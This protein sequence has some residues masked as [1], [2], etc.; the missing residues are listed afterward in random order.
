SRK[1][2]DAEADPKDLRSLRA[3]M[4]ALAASLGEYGAQPLGDYR[5][6]GNAVHN[7]L[8][9]L[10]SVLYNGEMRPVRRP[11]DEADIGRFLPYRRASFGLDAMELRGSAGSDF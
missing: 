4:Q 8:L 9:E 11:E 3:A 6:A 1:R 2:G 7:E 10:L 5:G